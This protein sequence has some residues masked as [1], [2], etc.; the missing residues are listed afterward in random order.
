[1]KLQRLLTALLLV[2]VIPAS[3]EAQRR[4][5]QDR[6]P[7]RYWNRFSL[8]PYAGAFKDAYDASDSNTG[9]LVG[10]RLGYE[11]GWRGRVMLNAGYSEVDDVASPITSPDFF[12]YD[13]NWI[14]TTL[15]GEFDVIPGNTSASVG[16]HGG[17]AW[18]KVTLDERIGD[19]I[20][21]P[22]D[23]DG[24]SAQG[25]LVPG[26]TVR[27]RI[28]PRAALSLAFEDYIFDLSDGPVDHSP[29]LSLG[30][31]FR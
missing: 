25:I 17:A 26:L 16:V 13:N 27:Q 24:Y 11:F 23:D 15:G 14:F 6:M 29:A 12:V 1:M 21:S 2:A 5:G 31:T 22:E 3:A 20:G 30:F 7:D 8:E 9:Y 10:M 19:P 28:G 18:R 4:R